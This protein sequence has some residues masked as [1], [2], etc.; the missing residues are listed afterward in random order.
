MAI[1]HHCYNEGDVFVAPLHPEKY[2]L[3][4][5]WRSSQRHEVWLQIFK[6]QNTDREQYIIDLFNL[7]AERTEEDLEEIKK[8]ETFF[9]YNRIPFTIGGVM[10]RWMMKQSGRKNGLKFYGQPGTG[11][12]TICNALVYPWHNAV[13]NTVQAVK[14]PSFMFQDCIGKSMILMEEPWFQKEVCE[15]MKKLLA[16]DHCH[17]DIKQG[18]QTT[19]AKLP[20]LISTNFYEM[21]GPSLE[22]ADHAALADRMVT[23]TISRRLMPQVLFKDFK[24]QTLTNKGLYQFIWA[25]KDDKY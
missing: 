9:K 18:H 16:G 8:W 22:Y 24:T 14:N 12:T 19:V 11:K 10:W 21:G 2:K 7:D 5:V 25:H 13:I 23:Y 6:Y 17:T 3:Y 1:K 20:V 15:E 4:Y